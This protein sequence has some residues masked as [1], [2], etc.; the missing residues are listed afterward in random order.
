VRVLLDAGTLYGGIACRDRDPKAIVATHLARDANLEVDDRVV[1]VLDPFFDHRNGFFFA[2]NPAGARSDGQISNNE[3]ALSYEWDGPIGPAGSDSTRTAAG[4]I[5]PDGTSPLA[6][7]DFVSSRLD[8]G[9]YRIDI[10]SGVFS[11]I[12]DLVVMPIGKAFVSGA[13]ISGLGG[14]AWRIEYFTVNIDSNQLQDTLTT[15]IATPFSQ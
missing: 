1:V 7:S 6:T 4:A 10:A 13:T 14:G 9:H 12:P 2:V 15:F 3:Q 5:N 11:T 8:V